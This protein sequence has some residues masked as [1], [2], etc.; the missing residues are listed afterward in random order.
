MPDKWGISM[1]FTAA[2]A[3]GLRQY[4][5]FSGR[6][7]RAEYSWFFLFTAL[8]SFVAGMVDAALGT[9]D[10]SGSIGVVG[11]LVWLALLLPSLA[12][13]ARR[14][15]DTDRSGWW[16]VAFLIPL[17][18]FVLWLVFMCSDSHPQTNRFGPSPKPSNVMPEFGHGRPGSGPDAGAPFG[19]GHDPRV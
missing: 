12:I 13:T 1:S 15:H 16:M 7:P 4:A 11:T 3:S 14:L 6:A 8:T 18:G 9:T 2:V 17:V 19:Y 5:T 10:S